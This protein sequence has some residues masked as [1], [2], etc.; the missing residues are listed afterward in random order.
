[1]TTSAHAPTPEVVI[2]GGGIAALELVLALRELAGDRL[3][4]TLVAAQPDFVLRPTLASEVLGRR[5]AERRPL[6]EIADD[7]GVRF[8]QGAVA[9]VDAERRH[10]VLRNGETLPYDSLVMA[11]GSRTVPAFDGVV[12]LGGTVQAQEIQTLRDEIGAGKVRSVAFVAPTRTGW[13]LPLYEAALMTASSGHSIR[14]TLVTRESRPLELFGAEASATVAAALKAAGITFIGGQTAVVSDGSVLLSRHP[15][16]SLSADRVVALP[17]VRGLRVPGIPTT[18]LYGL[19]GVDAYGR[20][21]G[22]TDVYAAGDA[23][24]YPVKQGDIACQQADAVAT[25]IAARHGGTVSASPFETVLRATLLTGT[26]ASIPLGPG[27]VVDEL[28]KVPGRHLAPYLRP[29]PIA[30]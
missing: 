19:I 13:L 10:V 26:G 5:A 14:V 11:H 6:S 15:L 24:D 23:T 17:L 3:R 16:G 22:L 30:A 2:V 7:L 20:V 1:M 29:E 28:G 9:S 21:K 4:M 27:A 25:T 18:G 8:L 12:E